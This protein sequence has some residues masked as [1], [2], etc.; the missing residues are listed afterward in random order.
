MKEIKD[1]SCPGIRQSKNPGIALFSASSHDDDDG[2]SRTI[3]HSSLL[4]A[5]Q[6]VPVLPGVGEH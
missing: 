2:S 1:N 4:S 5:N 3:I 6:P